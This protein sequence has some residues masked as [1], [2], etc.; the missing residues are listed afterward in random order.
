M[1]KNII[2]KMIFYFQFGKLQLIDNF[3]IVKNNFGIL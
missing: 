1:E 2:N 3:I